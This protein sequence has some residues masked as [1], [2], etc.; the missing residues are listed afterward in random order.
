MKL[1]VSL[2]LCN[3]FQPGVEAA[4]IDNVYLYRK[5]AFHIILEQTINL[6]GILEKSDY[7]CK[8]IK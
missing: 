3:S 4:D 2:L 7:V 5:L 1:F 8:L 6:S